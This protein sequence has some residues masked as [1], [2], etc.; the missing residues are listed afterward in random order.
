MRDDSDKGSFPSP[1][2][3]ESRNG[4]LVQALLSMYQAISAVKRAINSV[5][6]GQESLNACLELLQ[7]ESDR[8]H[9]MIVC[10][11]QPAERGGMAAVAVVTPAPSRVTTTEECPVVYRDL[12]I[13]RTQLQSVSN[14]V[15][16][17]TRPAGMECESVDPASAD[18]I[19]RLEQALTLHHDLPEG[20]SEPMEVISDSLLG[21]YLTLIAQQGLTLSSLYRAMMTTN[22]G[23]SE[24]SRE[25]DRLW[26]V[27]SRFMDVLREEVAAKIRRIESMSMTPPDYA[28]PTIVKGY[29][30]PAMNEFVA[31]ENGYL[32][33]SARVQNAW[34]KASVDNRELTTG[35]GEG[36]TYSAPAHVPIYLP[37]GRGQRFKLESGDYHAITFY[38]CLKY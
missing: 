3:D 20:Q 8:L 1:S 16:A 17:G 29:G 2:V 18:S 25:N 27:P 21:H 36:L 14:N 28:H 13:L 37:I 35:A 24:P 9:R 4:N 19:V 33:G 30:A 31:P 22:R 32:I 10:S 23:G 7:R 11:V 26:R 34:L 12:D 15:R 38:P 5:P 6:R